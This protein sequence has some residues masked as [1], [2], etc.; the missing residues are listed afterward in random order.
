MAI[1]NVKKKIREC[2]FAHLPRIAPFGCQPWFAGL[3]GRS[4][5]P[6]RQA[7]YFL[8]SA[9]TSSGLREPSSIWFAS[10]RFFINC[11]MPFSPDCALS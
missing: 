2:A 10:Q 6:S 4:N 8:G 7:T 1:A 3:A 5:E 11:F 9:L